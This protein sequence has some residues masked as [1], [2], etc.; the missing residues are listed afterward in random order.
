MHFF[1][2]DVIYLQNSHQHVSADILA[3]L[4]VMVLYNNTKIQMWLTV[5]TSL[6]NNKY[7]KYRRTYVGF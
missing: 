5:S 4:R 6:H 7:Y 3:T 1:I 2:Y